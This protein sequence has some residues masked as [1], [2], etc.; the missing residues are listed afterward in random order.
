MAS[1]RIFIITIASVVSLAAVAA[2]QPAP[3]LAAKANAERINGEGADRYEGGDFLRALSLFRRA[4]HLDPQP[5]Y[6]LNVALAAE[7]LDRCSTALAALLHYIELSSDEKE[8][9][10]KYLKEAKK[11]S[12]A[13][14]AQCEP[15]R[16]LF[17]NPPPDGGKPPADSQNTAAPAK[18]RRDLS[19]PSVIGKKLTPKKVMANAD[20]ADVVSAPIVPRPVMDE[21]ADNNEDVA[22]RAWLYTLGFGITGGVVL[23]YSGFEGVRALSD[24]E[25]LGA[26]RRRDIALVGSLLLFACSGASYYVH[27]K[28][29]VSSSTVT[30]TLG[31]PGDVGAAVHVSF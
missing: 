4:A 19:G 21:S 8:P 10:D 23:A 26:A 22:D 7:K 15:E 5:K 2:A 11:R 18:T 27:R 12:W 29:R 3:D 30:A 13:L 24:T 14:S 20:R 31:G 16:N 1:P 6:V 9:E 25:N 17:P 28:Y